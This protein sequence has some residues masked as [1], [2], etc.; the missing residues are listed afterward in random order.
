MDL[1]SLVFLRCLSFIASFEHG[2]TLKANRS[3]WIKHF[4]Y[5]HWWPPPFSGGCFP[6]L[7]HTQNTSFHSLCIF[8]HLLRVLHMVLS[9]RRK[10]IWSSLWWRPPTFH[11]FLQLSLDYLPVLLAIPV[12]FLCSKKLHVLHNSCF[13]GGKH[14]KSWSEVECNG[15]GKESHRTIGFVMLSFSSSWPSPFPQLRRNYL[16][17]CCRQQPKPAGDDL[18][19]LH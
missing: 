8:L 7:Q 1:S 14:G 4:C 15:A 11:L 12:L 10:A 6:D 3:C 17:L 19:Q 13:K 9:G 5:Q 18:V 16:F 2:S